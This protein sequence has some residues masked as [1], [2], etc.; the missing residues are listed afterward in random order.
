[1]TAPAKHSIV[2]VTS[3]DLA[4]L[5]E[6]LHA[7]K[8]ALTVNR[9]LFLD[10]PNDAVQKPAYRNAID[11]GFKDPAVENLKV[12][13][14]AS[15]EILAFLGLSRKPALKE[16][17]KEVG[18]PD[19]D[20]DTPEGFNPIVLKAVWKAVVEIRSEWNG[21]EH[22]EIT[23]VYVRPSSRRL[24]IGS[25]LVKL[26]F[27]RAKAE[28]LPLI[29]SSEPAAYDFFASL[30]FKDTRHVDWDLSK[31]APPHTGFG[32]FRMAGMRWDN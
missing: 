26:C 19:D 23:Y 8:L 5:A 15:G 21:F 7:S 30:G 28:G 31:W 27:E 13:D 2:P 14:A 18:I 1:M 20:A 6:Y 9:L 10:W 16:G 25:E 4:T 12:I 32:S 3:D 29:L 17:E 22:F 11:M 24:G